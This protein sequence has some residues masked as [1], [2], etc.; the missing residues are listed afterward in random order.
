MSNTWISIFIEHFELIDI[1]KLEANDKYLLNYFD[2]DIIIFIIDNYILFEV[3]E[4]IWVYLYIR[5][6]S[7]IISIF[8]I[9]FIYENLFL[10]S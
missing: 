5:D 1:N 10:K 9:E 3:I 4:Y 7:I 6:S 2:Y 8:S